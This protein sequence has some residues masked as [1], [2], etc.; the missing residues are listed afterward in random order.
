MVIAVPGSKVAL[1]VFAHGPTNQQQ[2]RHAGEP[3]AVVGVAGCS[4]DQ[5]APA[6]ALAQGEPL[7]Q[8]QSHR[9]L[10]YF[11]MSEQSLP[12]GPIYLDR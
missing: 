10:L 6:S 7:L 5:P 9:T 1:P 3:D 12:C 2:H 8:Q 4:E 11:R